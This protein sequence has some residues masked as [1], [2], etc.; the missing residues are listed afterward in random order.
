[1]KE[2][3]AAVICLQYSNIMVE[4]LVLKIRE[5]ELI[6]FAIY[7][8]SDCHIREHIFQDTLARVEEIGFAEVNSS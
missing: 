5:L 8:P 2:E 6:L 7:R 4:G 1:M 3:L